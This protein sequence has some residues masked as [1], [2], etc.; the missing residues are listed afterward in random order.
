[1]WRVRVR[2]REILAH[3]LRRMGGKRSFRIE[4]KRFD[5]ALED[6]GTHQVKISESGRYHCCNVYMGREGTKWLG[7]SLEENIARGGEQAFVRTRSENRKTYRTRCCRNN[8][9]HYLEV[10]ES[11]RGGSMGPMVI[12]KGQKQSGW[13]GFGKELKL[14]LSPEL[15]CTKDL[16]TKPILTHV[17]VGG[18]NHGNIVGKDST[19]N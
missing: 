10:T 14:L 4:S 3:C 7:W 1:M 8:Y 18:D 9:G 5:L 6:G 16:R 13:R 17:V 15:S 11:G 2:E 19:T 12:S